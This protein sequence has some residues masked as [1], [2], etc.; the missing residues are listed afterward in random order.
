MNFNC[1]KVILPVTIVTCLQLP[2]HAQSD[3]ADAIQLKRIYDEILV[4]G[5]AYKNLEELCLQ[6]GPRLSGSPQAVKSVEWAAKKMREAGADTVWLQEVTIPHWVR[7]EKEKGV[8]IRSDG[9]KQNVPTCA[10]GMSVGTPKEGITAEVVEVHDFEQLKKLGSENVKG[11]IVFY[12]HP[13][14]QRFVNTFDAYGEAGRYRY[15]GASEAAK[16][17]AVASIVRSLSSS[18]NDYPH[19]GAQRYLD[20]V[21]QNSLR[22][23]QH[24][25]G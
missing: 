3:S 23:Y 11:K 19:T 25:C 10:L 4:H 7:G 24:E 13:F 15:I 8:I 2:G 1:L 22:C 21:S 16:L 12:N 17:G 6:I 5:N 9:K 20:S 18:D 14:D